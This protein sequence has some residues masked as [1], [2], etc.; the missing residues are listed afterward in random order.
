MLMFMDSACSLRGSLGLLGQFYDF[1]GVNQ[2][3]IAF[4]D[5]MCQNC[6]KKRFPTP[7]C[8]P[9]KFL[10][11]LPFI[12]SPQIPINNIF[13]IALHP[14]PQPSHRYACVVKQYCPKNILHQT[15]KYLSQVIR[16]LQYFWL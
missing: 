8:L 6:K 16:E 2:S 12:H 15:L 4:S 3:L 7:H 11:L 9:K 5:E 13:L 14:K 10:N 1:Y